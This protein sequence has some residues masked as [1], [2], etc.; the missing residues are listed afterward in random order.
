M[1]PAKVVAGVIVA[2]ALA[3]GGAVTADQLQ[4]P[5]TTV[6]TQLEIQKAGTLREAGTVATIVNTDKPRIELRKWNG[7]TKLGVTYT[8]LPANTTGGRPFL[9]KNVEWGSGAQTMEAVPIDP[10]P[11][12]ED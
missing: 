9:S 6:G 8:G 12:I 2:G 10:S 7:E 11:E 5:Y 3:G 4:N 1:T